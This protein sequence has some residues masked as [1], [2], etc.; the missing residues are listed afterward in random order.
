MGTSAALYYGYTFLLS[1][2]LW[3][4]LRYARAE[5]KMVNMFCVYGEC[6]ML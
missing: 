3:L 1:F 2:V 6:F 4:G 5:L